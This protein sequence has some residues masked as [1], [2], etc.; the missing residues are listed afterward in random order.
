MRLMLRQ[1][2]REKKER[3]RRRRLYLYYRHRASKKERRESFL[4]NAAYCC[5]IVDENEVRVLPPTPS[6]LFFSK[7][8]W[9]FYVRNRVG[10]R[11]GKKRRIVAFHLG[12]FFLLMFTRVLSFSLSMSLLSFCVV[13]GK[14]AREIARV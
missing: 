4:V 13:S 10:K 7:H 1:E 3:E 9:F 5:V 8:V 12:A 14:T 11:K 6:F 2:E